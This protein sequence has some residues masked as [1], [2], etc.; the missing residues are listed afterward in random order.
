MIGI[1]TITNKINNKKYIG[2]SQNIKVRWK[3]HKAELRHN[4]HSNTYL[5]NSWNKYG[6][7]N[8]EFKI[9]EECNIEK[10]D[11]KEM[12]WIEFYNTVD[13]E[14]GYNLNNG[15]GSNRGIIPSE[16]TK[17][18]MSENHADVS[19]ENNPMYGKTLYDV[20]NEEEVATWKQKISYS[21]NYRKEQG[22]LP[23]AIPV[24]CLNNRKIYQTIID[25]H[26]D[27]CV[28][29]TNIS[30][31][32]KGEKDFCLSN[33]VF[34]VFKSVEEYNLM[35][36]NEIINTLNIQKSISKK[37]KKVVCLN[38][39]MIYDSLKIAEDKCNISYAQIS[40]CCN[41]NIKYISKSAYVFRFLEEYEKL[42]KEEIDQILKEAFIEAN[43]KKKVHNEIK[44]ICLNTLE[45]FKSATDAGEKLHIDNSSILKCCK[46]KIKS[47]G[48]D[49][50]GNKLK[51]MFY[52]E[53]LKIVNI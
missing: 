20:L 51:W 13:P 3:N 46:G 44:V 41:K 25:A 33:G 15:G 29:S 28:V 31:C 50:N 16:E 40:N 11:E 36:E 37:A 32:V 9:I 10:L 27:T 24:A 42:S 21:M 47:C 35:T 38:D 14:C 52:N 18:K 30:M 34:Y 2:Q 49:K 22:L 48:K 45:I 1:Y 26:N 7:H 23:N 4:H 17:R 6:E 43:Q 5:Q 53:Y 12:Y 39:G 19:G 8:F